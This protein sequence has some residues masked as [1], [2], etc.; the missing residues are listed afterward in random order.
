MTAPRAG[1]A[2]LL[3]SPLTADVFDRIGLPYLSESL[4]VTI[5]NCGN[6]V[7]IGMGDVSFQAHPYEESETASDPEEFAAI[8]ERLKPR[9]ALDFISKGP[10]TRVI[11][12]I[13]RK[14]GTEYVAQRIAPSPLPPLRADSPR[15]AIAHSVALARRGCGWLVRQVNNANPFPP[16]IAVLAGT[17]AGD[18]WTSASRKVVWTGSIDYFR[19]KAEEQARVAGLPG[20]RFH[21]GP[22]ALFIDDCLSLSLD[23]A[24]TGQPRPIE[25]DEYF[26]LLRQTFH[27]VEAALSLPVVIAG[28]PN[29]REVSDYRALFGDR[30]VHFE[31]TASLAVDCA[32]AFTHYSTAVAYPVLLRK[33]IVFLNSVKLTHQYPGHAVDNMAKLLSR[34]VLMMEAGC[35]A[36]RRVLAIASTVDDGAYQRYERRYIVTE[37]SSDTHHFESFVRLATGDRSA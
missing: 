13:L 34:P 32:I 24:I 33:P 4:D 35:D 18:Y 3:A 21:D 8:I 11:Q 27:H 19:L 22:F 7:R 16:D 26:P 23:Y 31:A 6:W 9:Y 30:P 25:P 12:D 14:H 37:R 17:E 28:H 29:G 15:G 36:C 2:I 5:L 10:Y 1:L 20:H